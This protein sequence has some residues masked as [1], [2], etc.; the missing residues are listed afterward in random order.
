MIKGKRK[1][2]KEK[3]QKESELKEVCKTNFYLKILSFF[4]VSDLLQKF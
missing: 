3:R 1:K 2:A 4:L